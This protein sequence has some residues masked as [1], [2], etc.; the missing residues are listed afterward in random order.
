MK[1]LLFI[2]SFLL[3]QGVLGQYSKDTTISKWTLDSLRFE[4]WQKSR[5]INSMH[6]AY[7][8]KVNASKPDTLFVRPD[9]ML[10]NFFSVDRKIISQHSINLWENPSSKKLCPTKT[11]KKYFNEQEK[12]IYIEYWDNFCYDEAE[13][14]DE[15]I[16]FDGKLAKEERIVYDTLGRIKKRLTYEYQSFK[17]GLTIQIEYS[18]NG[19]GEEIQKV[20]K[21]NRYNFWD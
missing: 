11:I 21:I 19:K 15:T 3:G 4:L 10:L 20:S 12:I 1:T 5:T 18:Y 16:R 8:M 13:K 14:E 9:S 7:K 2:S 6:W 17:E